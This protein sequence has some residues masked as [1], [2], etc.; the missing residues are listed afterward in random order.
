MFLNVTTSEAG[1][2]VGRT[3]AHEDRFHGFVCY[4]RKDALLFVKR[5]HLYDVRRKVAALVS[6]NP[7]GFLRQ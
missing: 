1:S 4:L 6:T 5:L 2:V 3:T 7:A